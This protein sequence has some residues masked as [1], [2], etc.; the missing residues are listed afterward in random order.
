MPGWIPSP[1]GRTLITILNRLDQER[2]F[3][4]EAVKRVVGEVGIILKDVDRQDK[5]IG[6]IK[7]V[8]HVQ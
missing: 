3:T 4:F 1:G 2:V 7:E 6:R 5:K 8:L